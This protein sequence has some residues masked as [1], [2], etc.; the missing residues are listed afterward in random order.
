MVNSH[1]NVDSLASEVIK[2]LNE[3]QGITDEIVSEAVKEVTKEAVSDL[4]SSSP[5]RTGYYA[6]SWKSG[7]KKVKKG[8]AKTVYSDAPHYRLTHL[9]ENGHASRNGGRVNAIT[10]IEPAEQ[11]AMEELERKIKEKIERESR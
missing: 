7:P 5:K 1:I 2:R 8:T 6:K 4:K 3:Y 9:L 11:N 10:H